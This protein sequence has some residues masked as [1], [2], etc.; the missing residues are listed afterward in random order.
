MSVEV[1][2]DGVNLLGRSAH[3]IKRNTDTVLV[4]SKEMGLEVN[5]EKSNYMVISRDQ[6][7]RRSQNIKIDNSFLV[8]YF[9][10]L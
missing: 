9:L 8:S 5:A 7:A 2:V 4:A 3:T 10:F 6:N 1:Y